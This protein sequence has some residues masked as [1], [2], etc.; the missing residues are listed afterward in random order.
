MEMENQDAKISIK[1]I[2][3][4]SYNLNEDSKNIFRLACNQLR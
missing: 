4:L 2:S 3:S 1:N